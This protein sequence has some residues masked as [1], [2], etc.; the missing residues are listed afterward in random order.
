MAGMKARRGLPEDV[1][2]RK[3]QTTREDVNGE[4][5]VY[6]PRGVVKMLTKVQQSTSKTD[7]RER[8]QQYDCF[9]SVDLP[10]NTF[11]S[12]LSQHPHIL[13]RRHHK[14]IQILCDP[15]IFDKIQRRHAQFQW[16][17]ETD[18]VI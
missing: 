1:N 13:E 2:E 18:R 8:T 14:F 5:T 17:S 11:A 3:G 10:V 9:I 7:G 15:H 6:N 4:W 12:Q 16:Y